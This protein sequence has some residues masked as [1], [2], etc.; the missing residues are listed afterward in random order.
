MR[1]KDS[2]HFLNVLK[3]NRG[4]IKI[5]IPGPKINGHGHTLQTLAEVRY[6]NQPTPIICTRNST[7]DHNGKPTYGNYNT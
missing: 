3:K 5:D 1:M 4:T 6:V 7:S 2:Y